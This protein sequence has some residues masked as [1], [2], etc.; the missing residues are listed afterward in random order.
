[1]RLCGPLARSAERLLEVAASIFQ[2]RDSETRGAA[3]CH[4]SIRPDR[5]RWRGGRKRDGSPYW[6]ELSSVSKCEN[7]QSFSVWAAAGFRCKGGYLNSSQP[8]KKPRPPKDLRDQQHRDQIVEAARDCVVRHGFHG[9]S[10]GQIAAA[11]NMSVGQIYRYFPSKEAIVHAIV[12]R[13]VEQREQV[14]VERPG[15][16]NGP[17]QIAESL[18]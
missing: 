2:L 3:P 14:M 1:M 7:E 4:V 10:M 6:S 5:A 15:R 11:A 18:V 9:T 12:E 8:A 17:Q 13:I 16:L